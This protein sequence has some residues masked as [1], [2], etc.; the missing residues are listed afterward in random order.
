MP[1]YFG[2][3]LDDIARGAELTLLNSRERDPGSTRLTPVDVVAIHKAHRAG[4]AWGSIAKRF[5]TRWKNV[6][7][8]VNGDRWADLH[9]SR[10]PDLYV[11]KADT[12]LTAVHAALDEIERQITA[13]RAAL[14]R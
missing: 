1:N 12:E 5:N 7:R 2:P 3:T 11:D 6:S 10:R 13:I 14:N 4:E 9:P 8:I